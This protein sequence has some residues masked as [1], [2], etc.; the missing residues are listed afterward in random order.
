MTSKKKEVRKIF[1]GSLTLLFTLAVLLAAG[2]GARATPTPKSPRPFSARRESEGGAVV[3]WSGDTRGY[4]P[5][6]DASIGITIENQTDQ[7]WRGRYCLNLMGGQSHQVIATLEQR[8]F[9]LSPGVGFSDTITVQLPEGLDAGAY[10][11]SLAVRRPGGAMVDLV[12]IQVGETDA[13]RRATTQQDMDASLAACPPVEGTADQLVELARMDLAQ[14][15]EVSPDEIAVQGVEPTEFP[16]ASLGVPEPG[17]DYAQVIT[18]GYIIDLSAEGETYRYHAAEERVVAVPGDKKQT[19]GG[20]ITVEGV[21]VT[22]AHVTIHGTS[23]LEEGACVSTELWAD[24]TPLS[25]WP[26]EACASVADGKWELVVPLED[27]QA[28]QSGVQYMIRAYQPG[29][30]NVISTFPFDLD[31]PPS[32][33]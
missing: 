7:D 13:V 12:P 31:G 18:P 22:A 19:P 3:A 9:E 10:G 28:L 25:W 1:L 16:N 24:G 6:D 21:E 27:D 5:G 29:G 17:E 32:E 23:T 15:L 11:L 2:C 26:V 4:E 8:T 14:R 33:E 20:S 30:P